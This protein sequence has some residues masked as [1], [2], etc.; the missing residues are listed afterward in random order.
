[1]NS[2]T[3]MVRMSICL[4]VGVGA[5][6]TPSTNSLRRIRQPREEILGD[7]EVVDEAATDQ[8]LTTFTTLAAVAAVVVAVVAALSIPHLLSAQGPGGPSVPQP[9]PPTYA[10]EPPGTRTW[11]ALECPEKGSCAAPT[12][13]DHAGVIFYRVRERHLTVRGQGDS[14]VLSLRVGQSKR[15]RWVLIGAERADRLSRLQVT[16]TPPEAVIVPAGGLSL[17]PLPH[18]RVLEIGVTDIGD[19]REGEILR[20]AEYEPR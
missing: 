12:V 16:L 17:F 5:C 1:M 19:P 20:I 11:Q 3:V 4:S 6:F 14:R 9:P 2:V 7:T 8:R 10:P 13:L 15:D 18:A